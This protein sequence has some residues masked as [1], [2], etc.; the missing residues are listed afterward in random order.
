LLLRV[1]GGNDTRSGLKLLLFSNL[2]GNMS[3]TM[4]F[5][6]CKKMRVEFRAEAFNV[7]N[8]VH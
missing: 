8:R 3:L 2:N 4:S 7:F 5:P 6:N 1:I